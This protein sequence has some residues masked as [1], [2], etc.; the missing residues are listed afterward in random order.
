M[1]SFRQPSSVVFEPYPPNQ[2]VIRISNFDF[3]V[4]GQLGGTINIILQLPVAGT[5][6]ITGTGVSVSAFL[7][8]QKTLNDEPYLRMTKCQIDGGV[9][10]SRVADMGLLTDTINAKYHLIMSSQAKVQLEDAICENVYRLTQQHF[11]SRLAKLPSHISA[12]TFF[13]TFLKANLRHAARAKRATDDY[14]D[15]LGGGEKK[16]S[17]AQTPSPAVTDGQPQNGTEGDE[18]FLVRCLVVV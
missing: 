14:Y 1:T 11:S 8:I 18:D 2:F 4:V 12:R 13:K 7:D 9:V 16:P 3:F 15:D 6:H 10:D 17:A 5:V